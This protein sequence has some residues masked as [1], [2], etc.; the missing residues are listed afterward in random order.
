MTMD[1]FNTLKEQMPEIAKIVTTFPEHIQGKVFDTL[2]YELLGKTEITKNIDIKKV[3]PPLPI[4]SDELADLSTIASVT[5]D[6]HYHLV[7]RDLKA[8]NAKDAVKRLVYVLIRSYTKL[9]NSTS[10]SRKDIVNPELT[11]WRL[12]DGN[13]RNYIATDRGILKQ[14]DQLCLD[15]HAQDEADQF[16]DDIN[17]PQII[18][19]WK[20]SSVKKVRRSKND[21]ESNSD[22]KQTVILTSE[23][24]EKSIIANSELPQQ[25]SLEELKTTSTI[26]QIL[27]A[28]IEKDLIL[29]AA[30]KYYL[31][32][33]KETF[34]RSDIL[35]E[36]KTATG[37][38]SDSYL[39]NATKYILIL[40]KE[41]KLRLVASDLY[42]LDRNTKRDLMHKLGL[43]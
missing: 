26:A 42:A 32:D 13:A 17:N 22:S 35:N 6:G 40:V 41:G 14:G 7:I 18:G 31:V 2:V 38:Y 21:H 3:N 16:I 33:K 34:N 37:Y 20:P 29:S 30:M 8:T 28:K 10:V 39:N 25:H 9:T 43:E 1:R 4:T 36:M 23:N 5:P 15:K 12:A 27:N 19:S 11:K 24:K